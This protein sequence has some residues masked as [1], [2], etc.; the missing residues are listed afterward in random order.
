[1]K[2]LIALILAICMLTGISSA[3]AF[4]KGDA[5]TVIG[6]DVTAGQK[7]S[8]YKSFGVKE[9]SVTELSITNAE[10]RKALS[11]LADP[12]IIG[13]SSISCVYVEILSEGDG[14]KVTV[15]NISLCT[16]EMYVSALNT[17]GIKNAKIVVTSP[18][19]GTTG[20]P[21]LA[22]I[23]K[24]YEDMSG[25]ELDTT[26]KLASSLE[27]VTTAELKDKIGGIKAEAIV[28]ELEKSVSKNEK[29]TD[30]EL[31]AK[32][33]S[34]AKDKN[35]TLSDSQVSELVSLYKSMQKLSPDELKA[36][37]ASVQDT[38]K[39]ISAA[40]QKIS[41]VLTSIGAF[42]KSVSSFFSDLFAKIGI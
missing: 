6:K 18:V 24:A 1:M 22:D 11:G 15:S 34:I 31:K 13:S 14:L 40:Q 8:V 5:R 29:L 17:A 33:Q 32:I 7:T 28:G 26:A 30:D 41:E 3:F 10:E 16:K 39:K 37:I 4:G 21:A 20:I 36:K 25:K 19:D 2:R 23:F 42:F 27:L 38:I 35:I 12:S 9:G